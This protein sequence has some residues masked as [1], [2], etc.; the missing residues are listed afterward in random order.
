MSKKLVLPS[1]NPWSGSK[2]KRIALITKARVL[3]FQELLILNIMG[4]QAD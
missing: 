4:L 1:E 2:D 3:R